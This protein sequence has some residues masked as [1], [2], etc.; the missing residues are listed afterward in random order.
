MTVR[1]AQ[2]KMTE[3]PVIDEIIIVE[4][5]D[6]E[7]AV[8]AAVS[9][10][11]I[12][13]EGYHIGKD[14]FN[15]I[16]KA[17]EGPGIVIFTDPDS[18]GEAIRRRL[19]KEFPASKQAFLIREDAIKGQDIGIENAPSD[20]IVKALKEAVVFRQAGPGA[21]SGE[22]GL[23]ARREEVFSQED[24]LYFDLM[25]TAESAKRRSKMGKA[26]GIGYANGKTF[27]ARLNGFGIT[28][29]EFYSHGNALFSGHSGETD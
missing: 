19:T 24:M 15:L 13:T 16:R 6:D 20:S 3:K 7:S 25:G 26:L 9:A 5:R 8:K 1:M 27:L 18:A 4:G 12:I 2:T 21:G 28:R 10:Q 17:Y 14:T 22:A 29:E 11:V 23:R